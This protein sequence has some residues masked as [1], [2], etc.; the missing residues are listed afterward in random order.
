[1]KWRTQG[2]TQRYG[3]EDLRAKLGVE[4]T[5]YRT[6][7]LFKSNV[8]DR[9][10]KEINELSDLKLDYEQFKNG[11]AITH[12]QF[13]IESDRFIEIE[14]VEKNYILSSK[15]IDLFSEKL[16]KDQVF[17]SLFAE[18]GET[19]EEFINRIK[20]LLSDQ[21]WVE[22]KAPHLERVGFQF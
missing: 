4:P 12:I 11:K 14:E 15:Q 17:G 8:L 19:G 18:V 6:M 7:S 22:D 13:I 3:I 20:V 16:A 2:R 1:M 21:S 5:Q 9:A 10:I